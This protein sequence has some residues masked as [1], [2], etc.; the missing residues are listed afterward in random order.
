M[1]EQR[2]TIRLDAELT[3]QLDELAIEG[4]Q[5]RSTLVR[6]AVSEYSVRNRETGTLYDAFRDCLGVFDGPPDLSTNP[7]YMEG[8]G[9]AGSR[10]D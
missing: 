8:F 3:R 4:G 1:K 5:S 9:R 7:K 10:S 6:E 2:V